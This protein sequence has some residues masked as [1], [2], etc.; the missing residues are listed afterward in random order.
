M[1]KT[2]I[3]LIIVL[4]S[5]VLGA[6]CF[7]MKDSPIFKISKFE[8]FWCREEYIKKLHESKSATN[9]SQK[10]D[11]IGITFLKYTDSWESAKY[12]NSH[13]VAIWGPFEGDGGI[14]KEAALLSKNKI[15]LIFFDTTI[16]RLDGQ[17][18]IFITDNLENPQKITLEY[19]GKKI[20]FVKLKGTLEDYI[21]LITLVG[22]YKD[23]NG[24]IYVFNENKTA[25]W[26][27]KNFKYEIGFDPIWSSDD[28]IYVI[29]ENNKSTNIIYCYEWKDDRLY[30]YNG[31]SDRDGYS[32]TDL[33]A[34]LQK[35][36]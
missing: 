2:L 24:N 30:I 11:Y 17:K 18:I 9:A 35:C 20:N 28:F 21:N 22:K 29:G 27:N 32:R 23:H 15:E 5:G 31:I 4:F 1:R 19:K 33:Y 12:Q 7:I 34:V 25:V 26:P 8:G 3:I 16:M 36:E 14:I 13:E 6:Y 10:F